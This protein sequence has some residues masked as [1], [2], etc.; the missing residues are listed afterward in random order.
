MQRVGLH[1]RVGSRCIARAKGFNSPIAQ[2]QFDR[3]CGSRSDTRRRRAGT[4]CCTGAGWARG[5][6]SIPRRTTGAAKG[7]TAG[8]G[9]AASLGGNGSTRTSGTKAGTRRS[10]ALRSSGRTATAASG[11]D[12]GTGRATATDRTDRRARG[13]WSGRGSSAG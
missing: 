8:R 13:C 2:G 5:R 10:A 4:K 12:A 7:G 9:C 11:A 1:E 6:S 3:L